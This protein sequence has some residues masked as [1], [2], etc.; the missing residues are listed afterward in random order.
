MAARPPKELFNHTDAPETGAKFPETKTSNLTVRPNKAR[1]GA[2]R[3][4][5]KTPVVGG[6][7]TDPGF[8]SLIRD[9]K[10]YNCGGVLTHPTHR[11]LR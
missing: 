1:S 2:V 6:G 3:A 7:V 9:Q 10:L 4:T 11:S 5:E 8:R